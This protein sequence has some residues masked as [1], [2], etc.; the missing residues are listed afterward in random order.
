[1]YQ[2]DKDKCLG[3]G[4]CTITCPE[5]MKIGVDGKAEV[6]DEDALL[7]AGGADIC[8][9]GAIFDIEEEDDS[10]NNENSGRLVPLHHTFLLLLSGK[11]PSPHRVPLSRMTP[12]PPEPRTGRMT[13]SPCCREG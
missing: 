4:G 2:I 7:K 3:C 10:Q 13:R 5:G 12:A 6:I 8:P 9:Y 11:A 1:M